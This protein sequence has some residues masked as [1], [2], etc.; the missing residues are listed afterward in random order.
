[1]IDQACTAFAGQA[2]SRISHED[3][4]AMLV[5]LNQWRGFVL[6]VDGTHYE[7]VRF[8]AQE[9]NEILQEAAARQV[10]RRLQP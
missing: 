10:Q 9:F 4:T 7:N 2:A 1:M 8:G 5:L 3:I 6:D